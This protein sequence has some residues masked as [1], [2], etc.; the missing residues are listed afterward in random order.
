MRLHVKDFLRRYTPV[1]KEAHEKGAAQR[2]LFF[3]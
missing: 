1:P 2:P 3:P